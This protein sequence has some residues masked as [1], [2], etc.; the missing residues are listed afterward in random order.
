M[1]IS[2]LSL[3]IV[4]FIFSCNENK[5]VSSMNPEN[6]SK[7]NAVINTED[8]LEFGKSY[9]SIY[10]QIYSLS[11]H[12][13]HN[14][15][16]MVSLRNTSDS[17]TIYILKAE[18][19]DTHGKSIRKYFDKPIFL[20]PME[21]TEIIIDEIDISGGTGSNFMFD[22]KIPKNCSEPLFEAIMSSTM[23]QQGLSFT[24]QAV[25]VK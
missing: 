7:R 10:S 14:L 8:S 12:K 17:D 16:A 22:W 18:Y 2:Y 11:E 3:L 19:Y 21:T 9:L 4:L 1:K 15:T 5:E 20:A 25:R 13:T 24:T 23:S 6:W